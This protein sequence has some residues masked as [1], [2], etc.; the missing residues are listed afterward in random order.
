MIN[1]AVMTGLVPGASYSY[2]VGSPEG[3]LSAMVH[4]F[5]HHDIENFPFLVMSRWQ[6][7]LISI[8]SPPRRVVPCVLFPRQLE[9]RVPR[10]EV[11]RIAD[12]PMLSF[13]FSF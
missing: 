11:Q 4:F 8:S 13:H 3:I 2:K 5:L 9:G 6:F 12:E 7:K 10:L 1:D